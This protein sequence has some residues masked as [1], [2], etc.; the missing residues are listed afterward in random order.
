MF[1]KY[2]SIGIVNTVLHWL[3]FSICFFIISANQATSNLVAFLV[4][5]TFSFF[6]KQLEMPNF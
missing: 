1:L 6:M 5:V 4:A 2:F 3:M